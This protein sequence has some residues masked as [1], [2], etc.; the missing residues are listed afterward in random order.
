MY[1]ALVRTLAVSGQRRAAAGVLRQMAKYGVP[2]NAVT[3]ELARRY[4]LDRPDGQGSEGDSW[5]AEW[6]LDGEG[7]RA[8]AS[9]RMEQ[10]RESS[11][12]EER[13]GWRKKRRNKHS[14][15]GRLDEWA[16]EDGGW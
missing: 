5:R 10:W 6:T 7:E 1:N 9:R 4:E 8:R 16:E 13:G 2:G 11:P 14:L 3:E 12:V 15:K